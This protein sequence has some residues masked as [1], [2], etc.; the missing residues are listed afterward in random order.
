MMKYTFNSIKDLIKNE[1]ILIDKNYIV[2]QGL[3]YDYDNIVFPN[4][5]YFIIKIHSKKDNSKKYELYTSDEFITDFVVSSYYDCNRDDKE[6]DNF[7]FYAYCLIKGKNNNKSHIYVTSWDFEDFNLLKIFNEYYVIYEIN[8]YHDSASINKLYNSNIKYNC[9]ILCD[10]ILSK[11]NDNQ[12]IY[13]NNM[14]SYDNLTKVSRINKLS[15]DKYYLL[16][17]EDEKR[18]IGYIKV[19]EI[20]ENTDNNYTFKCEFI[21]A[22]NFAICDVE[23]TDYEDGA[24]GMDMDYDDNDMCKITIDEICI[25]YLIENVKINMIDDMINDLYTKNH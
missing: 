23:I 9:N 3:I 1:H 24:Y 15:I 7:H 18:E 16:K 5:N 14:V 10:T 8:L 22:F 17:E 11:I 25:I 2:G 20:T 4:N 19:I 6:F 13:I 21:D 12:K